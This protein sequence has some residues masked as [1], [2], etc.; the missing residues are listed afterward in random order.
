MYLLRTSR[1]FIAVLSA[2]SASSTLFCSK[3]LSWKKNSQHT[4]NL[5]TEIQGSMKE[6]RSSTSR[7]HGLLVAETVH[8]HND[9][10]AAVSNMHDMELPFRQ[11][12][13]VCSIVSLLTLAA[14]VRVSLVTSSAMQNTA[15]F[16]S[17]KCRRVTKRHKPK[18]EVKHSNLAN[19]STSSH[20]VLLPADLG[21]GISWLLVQQR[22]TTDTT[23][24]H[25][26]AVSVKQMSFSASRLVWRSTWNPRSFSCSFCCLSN[27]CARSSLCSARSSS[28]HTSWY[29]SPDTIF[30][31]CPW[32]T[33]SALARESPKS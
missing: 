5:L 14:A 12:P 17:N 29:W 6:G 19:W 18:F 22:V 10:S 16:F 27:S 8:D 33:N 24:W 15:W 28:R 3:V 20:F 25:T 30:S 1:S 2:F 32:N 21:A 23:F 4:S 9:G 7:P 11:A 31:I 26:W 13:I